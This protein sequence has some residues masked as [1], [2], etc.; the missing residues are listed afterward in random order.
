MTEKEIKKKA[1]AKKAPVKKKKA[2]A[3]KKVKQRQ[4]GGKRG[5]IHTWLEPENLLRI[6]GWARDGLYDK[7]I[8]YNIGIA[9][10]TF[11]TWKREREP[12]RQA[13]KKGKEVV[14]REVENALH[15]SATG[16]WVEEEESLIEIIGDREKRK[17]RITKKWVPAQAVAQIYWL[18]NRK[19]D[20]W[21]ERKEDEVSAT[22]NVTIVDRW[23]EKDETE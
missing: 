13:L 14:D 1:P 6:Q 7:Q 19:P 3:K 17:K 2:A 20:E 9:E 12:I 15:K 16:Y 11:S 18:K 23:S 8:A 22:A 10:D 4:N 21:K 5:V